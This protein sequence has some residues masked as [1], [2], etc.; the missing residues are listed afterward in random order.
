MTIFSKFNELLPIY[1]QLI[2]ENIGMEELVREIEITEE[3]FHSNAIENSSLSLD[4]TEQIINDLTFER[5]T[6]VREI[7]EAKNLYRVYTFIE[8]K[9]PAITKENILLIHKLL[10]DNI[11]D[12]IAGRFR[13]IGE[14]VKV[15]GY[16][17]PEAAK[18]E[19]LMDELLSRKIE[20]LRDV[21]MFHIDFERVH[22]FN[23]GNGRIGRV[24]INWQLKKIK[25][26][27]IRIRSETKYTRYY[28]HI[29]MVDYDAFEK[30]LLYYEVE[31]L[32]KRIAFLSQK[33]RPRLSFY[34]KENNLN[35]SGM[36]QKAHRQTIPAFRLKGKWHIGVE[37]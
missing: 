34:S 29:K 30:Q 13:E 11:D 1:H 15:G 36:L 23:D 18:V 28:P 17:A 35:Y 16:Y 26:P 31:S 5:R 2:Q 22:P 32:H 20:T 25:L 24:L 33:L 21:S 4:E 7:Y 12:N 9:N 27:P 8:N 10:I 3:V 19:S 14:G 6:F 37:K